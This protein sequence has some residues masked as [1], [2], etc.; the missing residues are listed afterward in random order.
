MEL[1]LS[2][3]RDI[4]EQECHR[5]GSSGTHC[6]AY[7]TEISTI[8]T[9]LDSGAVIMSRLPYTAVSAFVP[10]LRG[11]LERHA[12]LSG[13]DRHVYVE[14]VVALRRLLKSD[15]DDDS[16][17]AE[18]RRDLADFVVSNCFDDMFD[19]SDS[20]ILENLL[21]YLHMFDDDTVALAFTQPRLDRILMQ[22]DAQQFTS[23]EDLLN[24]TELFAELAT[25]LP[26]FAQRITQ[27]RGLA[28]ILYWTHHKSSGNSRFAC[29]L[30][31][32]AVWL[33]DNILT[34]APDVTLAAR[35]LLAKDAMKICCLHLLYPVL[36]HH[37]RESRSALDCMTGKKV[38]RVLRVLR[39]MISTSDT[40]PG[41]A[42]RNRG[43]APR[44][45]FL[46]QFIA[47]NG[48]QALE[49]LRYD[50]CL[51]TSGGDLVMQDLAQLRALLARM[52]V[53]A[54]DTEETEQLRL[55]TLAELQVFMQSQKD[56]RAA[57]DAYI[58][59]TL[60][61]S[62][63][64]PPDAKDENRD[65]DDG[66][67]DNEAHSPQSRAR[68]TPSPALLSL[69][70]ARAREC[71]LVAAFEHTY[72]GLDLN[73]SMYL[74]HSDRRQNDYEMGIRIDD[75]RFPC[76]AAYFRVAASTSALGTRLHTCFV[77]QGLVETAASLP[78]LAL[79]RLHSDVPCFTPPGLLPETDVVY[80]EYAPDSA[81]ADASAGASSVI[82]PV[83]TVLMY[84]RSALPSLNVFE[85]HDSP[86]FIVFKPCPKRL[87]RGAVPVGRV[88]SCAPAAR[89][90]ASGGWFD[91]APPRPRWRRCAHASS[92]A[93]AARPR[94][95]PL[96][97][98]RIP[99]PATTS[100]STQKQQRKEP[101]VAAACAVRLGTRSTGT[102]RSTATRPP[103][104]SL[105]ATPLARALAAPT[106]AA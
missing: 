65:C 72:R 78:F 12:S 33:F 61:Q 38:A 17:N 20:W 1:L 100:T 37:D 105:R 104:L 77:P 18:R 8:I 32:G 52:A 94:R 89:C 24:A 96:L 41:P 4:D 54:P 10:L 36:T 44:N 84:P 82:Y 22:V 7:H 58:S 85:S 48:L 3:M 87:L 6:D 28:N 42:V 80:G 29:N 69:L 16:Y 21:F 63:C 79:F 23:Y 102:C 11:T 71:T 73:F 64:P 5:L 74:D 83:G 66:D 19:I 88:V 103:T 26:E 46:A 56:W 50:E 15:G 95:S 34:S 86:W 62:G 91:V 57:F 59:C 76:N 9:A 31:S 67:V 30:L 49:L 40:S 81:H 75:T 98:C 93:P 47:E 55:Q 13:R 106:R 53:I 39:T 99:S 27:A 45:P 43:A 101:G 25:K 35:D 60:E 2:H 14:S 92:P 90:G 68:T 51:Q 70:Q 97:R